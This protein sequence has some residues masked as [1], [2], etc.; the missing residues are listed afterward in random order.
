MVSGGDDYKIRMWDVNTKK[1]LRM[2]SGWAFGDDARI[3]SLLAENAALGD[4]EDDAKVTFRDRSVVYGSSVLATLET[5]A[6]WGYSN[7]SHSLIALSENGEKLSFLEVV[8]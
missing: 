8:T 4:D 1:L 6:E 5:N 7:V 2:E 3:R